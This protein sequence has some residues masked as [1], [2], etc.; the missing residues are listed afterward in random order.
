MEPGQVWSLGDYATVGDRWSSAGI[1][2]A[3]DLARPEIRFLDV[4][5]G[6]GAMAL[7]AARTG[8]V[9]TGLDA[10]PSLL[11]HARARAA[12]TG[13]TWREADMTAM[14]FADAS[15]DVVA[16]AFGA[17]FA[18][19]PSAMADELRR[20][21]A[22][23]GTVAVLA[24]TPESPFGMLRTLASAYLPPEA[25][26]PAIEDWGIPERVAVFFGT[27][28]DTEVRVVDVRWPS[29]NQAVEEITTLT[30][31]MVLVRKALEADGTWPRLVDEVTASF[32]AAGVTDGSGYRLP[33]AYL[34][35]T[36]RR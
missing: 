22:P 33:V 30:P 15:F 6:P 20:V 27:P 9:A 24:W 26:G 21:C 19:D 2:L 35:T 5:C 3:R 12:G 31:G 36:V 18:P 28:V 17:M 25:A 16:S 29:L 4:A 1:S 11:D 7:T 32:T 13:I 34:R 8:A 14:P 23:D 10:S